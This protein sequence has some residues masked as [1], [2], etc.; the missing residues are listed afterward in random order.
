MKLWLRVATL[1]AALAVLLAGQALP[2]QILIWDNDNGK[3]FTDPEGAG[4]VGCEYGIQEAL[5][6]NGH[7][8]TTR[9]GTTLPPDISTYDVI[10]VVLGW[11]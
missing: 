9:T 5:T 4:T 8:Y 7:T 3:T 10:Y 11:C 2:Q 1:A 6:A